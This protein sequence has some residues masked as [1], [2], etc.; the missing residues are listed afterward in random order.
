MA[1]DPTWDPDAAP[2][3]L[4][5][6]ERRGRNTVTASAHSGY[7]SAD[8]LADARSFASGGF[9]ETKHP[10][11]PAGSDKGG[12]FARKDDFVGNVHAALDE[13]RATLEVGNVRELP[14]EE[15]E[16]SGAAMGRTY[17]PT[18]RMA[19]LEAA[20]TK[21]GAVV[22]AEITRRLTAAGVE[23]PDDPWPSDVAAYRD[24]YAQEA[25]AVLGEIRPMG[26]TFA[27][28]ASSP[29]RTSSEMSKAL[30]PA[31]GAYPTDWITR[32][33]SIA[34]EIQTAG[35][36]RAA[37]YFSRGRY[38][39]SPLVV[40]PGVR[41][42]AGAPTVVHELGHR[43][44]HVVPGVKEMEFAFYHRRTAG[45]KAAPLRKLKP[46]APF[47]PDEWGYADKF[48]DVYSGK[49]MGS[50]AS[51]S[52]ELFT[53][54]AQ[55]YVAPT[56]VAKEADWTNVR[57]FLADSDYRSWFFGVMATQ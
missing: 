56:M 33:N 42:K 57:G 11:H 47:R 1:D 31:N 35:G 49:D 53:M 44:E 8:D 30:A 12:E 41:N 19:A 40:V 18:E 15:I 55:T 54:G 37:G 26:G 13:Y 32:S 20:S 51:S 14:T 48:A 10:R 43:M 39:G 36:S 21:V 52:Y 6:L 34:L 9:D 2:H 3:R 50:R 16:T 24:R 29:Q 17:I 5:V 23:L 38:G 22:D 45:E 28:Q 27:G 25:T 7:D 46:L 4:L